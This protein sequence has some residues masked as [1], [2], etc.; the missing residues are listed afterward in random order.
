MSRS[1][2]AYWEKWALQRAVLAA[3]VRLPKDVSNQL[4]WHA[5]ITGLQPCC[6]GMELLLAEASS[7][8]IPHS[9]V[10]SSLC[11]THLNQDIVIALRPWL[12]T[13]GTAI[14]AWLH[15]TQAH[16]AHSWSCWRQSSGV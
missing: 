9:M 10:S 5:C 12:R 16:P 6:P 3:P 14:N 15:C 8:L 13:S 11:N 1:C 7:F 4:M 2:S